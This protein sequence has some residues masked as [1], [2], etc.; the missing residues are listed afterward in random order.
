MSGLL[1]GVATQDR[2]PEAT[3]ALRPTGTR[4]TKTISTSPG[5][6][7][8]E[9]IRV[10][11]E[12]TAGADDHVTGTL[13]TGT[14]ELLPFDGWLEL[15]RL[16]EDGRTLL[17]GGLRTTAVS[18]WSARTQRIGRG[19]AARQLDDEGSATAKARP[20]RPH[21][22]KQVRVTA[23]EAAPGL[24]RNPLMELSDVS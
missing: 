14:G 11:V 19:P 23:A 7:Q 12:V 16:I 10:I 24:R 2:E 9:P 22:L 5:R 21:S 18:G 6:R 20:R 3:D 15:M 4:R 8:T 13:A 17:I 1:R